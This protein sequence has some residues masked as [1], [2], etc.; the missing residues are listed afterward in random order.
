[1]GKTSTANSTAMT[2]VKVTSHPYWLASPWQTPASFLPAR[3]RI[4]GPQG[5]DGGREANPAEPGSKT[6]LPQAEQKRASLFNDAPHPEQNKAIGCLQNVIVMNHLQVAL[7]YCSV[8]GDLRYLRAQSAWAESPSWRSTTS[9]CLRAISR[10]FKRSYILPE[11]R[12][13]RLLRSLLMV[14]CVVASL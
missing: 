4:N 11:L 12:S 6:G 2:R 3:G 13:Q 10:S 7:S 14:G 8:N 1:M 9:Y 5:G